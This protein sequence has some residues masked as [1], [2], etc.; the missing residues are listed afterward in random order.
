MTEE[1]KLKR[2]TIE[3]C[4]GLTGNDLIIC[5]V[6][7]SVYSW[8]E[9]EFVVVYPRGGN[10]ELYTGFDEEAGGINGYT[11]L[12]LANYFDIKDTNGIDI[13]SYSVAQDVSTDDWSVA[14]E[15]TFT[16]SSTFTGTDGKVYNKVPGL[17]I[18]IADNGNQKMYDAHYLVG[19]YYQWPVATAQTPEERQQNEDNQKIEGSICPKRWILPAS[20]PVYNE[21]N[22]SFYNSLNTYIGNFLKTGGTQAGENIDMYN[23]SNLLSEQIVLTDGSTITLEDF[24]TSSPFEFS[25]AGS[26]YM[27]EYHE[28]RDLGGYGGQIQE[29]FR[30]SS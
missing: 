9:G 26:V 3:N 18:A 17:A 15:S 20:G 27:E 24:L 30:F 8:N 25:R 6:N 29:N 14:S 16:E 22:G 10:T 21:A 7:H 12:K 13:S 28:F 19:N 1:E 11:K 4:S 2:F 5:K 23:G